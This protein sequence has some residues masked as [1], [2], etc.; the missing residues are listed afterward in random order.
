MCLNFGITLSFLNE[1]S[2]HYLLYCY[3]SNSI[4][5][6]DSDDEDDDGD[7]ILENDC[8]APFDQRVTNSNNTNL[9][10]DSPSN[11]PH[12]FTVVRPLPQ[13]LSLPNS[14]G[15]N[16]SDSSMMISNQNG[17]PTHTSSSSLESMREDGNIITL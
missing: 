3:Y 14:I 4:A 17:N 15:T 16:I 12:N 13:S 7:L 11:R 2:Y 10:N 1:F 8:L 5:E 9:N 6:G